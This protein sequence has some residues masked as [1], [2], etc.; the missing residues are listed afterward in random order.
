MSRLAAARATLAKT[1]TA[2]PVPQEKRL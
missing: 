1:T 2:P